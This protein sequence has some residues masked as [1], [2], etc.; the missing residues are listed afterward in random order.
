[1]TSPLA[2]R[3][4]I[5][6]SYNSSI[7]GNTDQSFVV[8][9]NNNSIGTGEAFILGGSNSQ[10]TGGGNNEIIGSRESVITGGNDVSLIN[11]IGSNSGSYDR[12]VML[13]TSGRTSTTSS[14]TFVENL[15]IFNYANL[16]YA[17][18][19]AAAAGGVVLGQV[20][21]NNGALRIRHT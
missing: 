7:T 10:I 11:T 3:A 13:G 6:S 4:A 5:I 17:N 2:E 14:A 16:D 19:A 20:Y 8:G 18:D 21:H 12:V 15:V 9:G 1:M